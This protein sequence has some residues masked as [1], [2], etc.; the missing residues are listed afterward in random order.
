MS[1]SFPQVSVANVRVD[2]F[3]GPIMNLKKFIQPAL[4][5]C[6]ISVVGLYVK[7]RSAPH[8]KNWSRSSASNGRSPASTFDEINFETIKDYI[9]YETYGKSVEYNVSMNVWTDKNGPLLKKRAKEALSDA[10]KKTFVEQAMA[11]ESGSAFNLVSALKSNVY[12]SA[13]KKFVKSLSVRH[14]LDG[15]FHININFTPKFSQNINYENE[16]SS[17]QLIDM[18]HTNGLMSEVFKG[19]QSSIQ[20]IWKNG[21][22]SGSEVY[23][24]TGGSIDIIVK[25]LDTN[26][27]LKV[28]NPKK[29]LVK[30]KVRYRKYIKVNNPSFVSFEHRFEEYHIY[31]AKFKNTEGKNPI[32][33]VDLFKEFNL[34]N[35]IP[36]D[37]LL[38]IYPGE[39]IPANFKADDWI[40]QVFTVIL[41]KN[42]SSIKTGELQLY[43]TYRGQSFTAFVDKLVYSIPNKNFT[44]KSKIRIR[45]KTRRFNNPLRKKKIKSYILRNLKDNFIEELKLEKYHASFKKFKE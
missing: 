31:H 30:G 35:P 28:P 24:Y 8:G 45:I 38:V 40:N 13:L 17:N 4:I 36:K 3:E 16:L 1:Y 2:Y 34:E 6:V 5:I 14:I 25:L 20:N 43:G 18:N 27:R 19:T 22:V 44:K 39:L 21:M 10:F 42:E 15:K 23:Q 37:K 9:D 26:V 32:M 7:K 41:L 11:E 33:T 29:N 12:K